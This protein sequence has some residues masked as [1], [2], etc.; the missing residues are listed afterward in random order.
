MSFSVVL[1]PDVFADYEAA[2]SWYE[3]EVEGLGQKFL[4]AVRSKLETIAARPATFSSKS[5]R[6]YPEAKVQGFPFVIVY[7]IYK[8]KKE[9]FVASIH[10]L[11]KNP[12]KKYRR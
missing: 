6:D 8:Q 10:H 4:I 7:K 12:K 11:K 1:H 9:V 3:D 2:Y 5:K